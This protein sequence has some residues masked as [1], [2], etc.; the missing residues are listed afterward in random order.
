[1]QQ[2]DDSDEEMEANEV[3]AD[4]IVNESFHGTPQLCSLVEG[5]EKDIDVAEETL[6]HKFVK[7]G[8]ANCNFGNNN[9]FCCT[10]ICK[11]LTITKQ[12]IFRCR[13]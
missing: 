13:S 6:I 4:A 12:S 9:S 8:C 5:D 2:Q 1:M 11:L 7:E 3:T 10:S